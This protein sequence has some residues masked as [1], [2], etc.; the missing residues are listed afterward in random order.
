MTTHDEQTSAAGPDFSDR[1]ES[2][3]ADVPARDAASGAPAGALTEDNT[4]VVRRRASVGIA[5][6]VE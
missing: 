5:L 2:R 3:G 4:Y 1:Q 6:A